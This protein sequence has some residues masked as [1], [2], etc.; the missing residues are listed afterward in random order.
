[1]PAR[2]VGKPTK[3]QHL[4]LFECSCMQQGRRVTASYGELH[5]SCWLLLDPFQQPRGWLHW[6]LL[7]ASTYMPL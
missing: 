7:D 6:K 5:A 3:A 1:M 4:A 2:E